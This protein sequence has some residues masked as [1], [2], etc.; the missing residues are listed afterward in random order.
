[1]PDSMKDI[2]LKTF[3]DFPD[4]TF[5]WKYEIDNGIAKGYA[6]VFTEKWLPQAELLGTINIAVVF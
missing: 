3:A 2:F 5:L 1:M 6:N 4:I